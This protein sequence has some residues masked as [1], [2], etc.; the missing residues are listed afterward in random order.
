MCLNHLI[1]EFYSTPNSSGSDLRDLDAQDPGETSAETVT[2]GILG[3]NEAIRSTTIT[4]SYVDMK[5]KAEDREGWK[6]YVHCHEPAVKQYTE[7]E[8]F[9]YIFFIVHCSLFVLI[10]HCLVA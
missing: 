5:R 8:I 9:P 6:G 3:N 7:R 1:G 4:V 2:A 10:F